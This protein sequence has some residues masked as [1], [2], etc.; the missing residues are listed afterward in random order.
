MANEVWEQI[1]EKGKE[2]EPKLRCKKYYWG[3]APRGLQQGRC[4]LFYKRKLEMSHER[5]K[6]DYSCFTGCFTWEKD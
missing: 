5:Y 1:K 6:N 3:S 2:D 4:S